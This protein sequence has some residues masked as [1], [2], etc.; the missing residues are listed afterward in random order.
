MVPVRQVAVGFHIARPFD[1]DLRSHVGFPGIGA[2]QVLAGRVQ[3]PELD[4][5]VLIERVGVHDSNVHRA[6]GRRLCRVFDFGRFDKR[7]RLDEIR[8]REPIR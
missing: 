7:I 3:R 4:F 6:A 8:A 5:V 1:V 2:R